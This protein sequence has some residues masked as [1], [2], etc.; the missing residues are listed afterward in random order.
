MIVLGKKSGLQSAEL[1]R[2]E[3]K[4]TRLQEDAY[5]ATMDS[6]VSGKGTETVYRDK[7]GRKIDQKLE[8][9]KKREIEEKKAKEDEK[10]LKWGKG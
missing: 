1:L 6:N 9:I 4:H 2:E 7:S 3:N 8:R 10:F 5:F